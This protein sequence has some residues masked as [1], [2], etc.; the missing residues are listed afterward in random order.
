MNKHKIFKGIACVCLGILVVDAIVDLKRAID[1]LR[2]E[3]C[4]DGCCCGEGNGDSNPCHMACAGMADE[5]DFVDEAM[6]GE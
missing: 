3:H 4:C 1:G 2:G 6:A 5:D